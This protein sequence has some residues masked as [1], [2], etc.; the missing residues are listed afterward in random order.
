MFLNH[1][2]SWSMV[3][4]LSSLTMTT[5]SVDRNSTLSQNNNPASVEE[6]NEGCAANF[7]KNNLIQF[8][9]VGPN[10]SK[11]QVEEESNWE[12][13]NSINT[14]DNNNVYACVIFVDPTYVTSSGGLDPLIDLQASTSL[15]PTSEIYHIVD[16]EDSSM[17]IHNNQIQP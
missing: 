7:G 1:I 8:K 4:M 9:Y 16:S 17:E 2:I 12:L 5:G 6:A 11:A 15:P 10:F 3:A 13:D 14:C